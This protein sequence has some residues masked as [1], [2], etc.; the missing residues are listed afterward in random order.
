MV[1]IQWVALVAPRTGRVCAKTLVSMESGWVLQWLQAA[2]VA[3]LSLER[4]KEEAEA[5]AATQTQGH[6]EEAETAAA[7]AAAR[8]ECAGQGTAGTALGAG[9]DEGRKKA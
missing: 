6:D 9:W 4:V 7:A 1:G 3:A 8:Q 5:A 2:P